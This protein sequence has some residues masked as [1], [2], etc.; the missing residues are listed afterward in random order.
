MA[1]K[2]VRRGGRVP[3]RRLPWWTRERERDSWVQVPSWVSRKEW[4]KEGTGGPWYVGYKG[5]RGDKPRTCSG[6]QCITEGAK[7]SWAGREGW[8]WLGFTRSIGRKGAFQ[9]GWGGL[10]AFAGVVVIVCPLERDCVVR[11]KSRV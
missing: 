1:R 10:L 8:T 6:F 3:G 11:S 5:G 7:Y 2:E 4:A 9:A